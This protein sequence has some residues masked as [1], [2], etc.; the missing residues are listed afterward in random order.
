MILTHIHGHAEI[1][2]VGSRRRDCLL[3]RLLP[4]AGQPCKMVCGSNAGTGPVAVRVVY[5]PDN[6]VITLNGNRPAEIVVGAD[7]FR[8]QLGLLDERVVPDRTGEHV[9]RTRPTAVRHGSVLSAHDDVV[10]IDMY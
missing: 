3:F 6:R 9:G 8:R 10:A 1:V 2:A 7:H 4:R 5:G